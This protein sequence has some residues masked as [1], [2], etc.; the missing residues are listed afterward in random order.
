MTR[1]DVVFGP[2]L[3]LLAA[4]CGPH[5]AAA[6][7]PTDPEALPEVLAGTTWRLV[8]FR[9]S[10]DGIGVQRPTDASRYT[11]SL[12][13]SG[14]VS[15]RL[16]CNWARGTW[17]ATVTGASFGF[18]ELR[19]TRALCQQ[20]SLDE[21]IARHAEFVSSFFLRDGLLFLN[22]VADGGTYVWEPLRD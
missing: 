9:S 18:G 10:D 8:E 4:A 22:L 21:Q 1:R 20:P 7:T 14:M 16:D 15:M 12:D 2:L 11:M 5:L 19:V 3:V 13:E 6:Q 17:T